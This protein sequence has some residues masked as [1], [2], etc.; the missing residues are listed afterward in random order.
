MGD[1][2]N[3]RRVDFPAYCRAFEAV[4]D[5]PGW[6]GASICG[7]LDDGAEEVTTLDAEKTRYFI[8]GAFG[9]G[10]IAGGH[11]LDQ[12]IVNGLRELYGICRD[13]WETCMDSPAAQA[14]RA[15]WKSIMDARQELGK[16]RGEVSRLKYEYERAAEEVEDQAALAS[17]VE[18]L[19]RAVDGELSSI[20]RCLMAE[21]S[22]REMKSIAESMAAEEK[23]IAAETAEEEK[24]REEIDRLN[25]FSVELW[26]DA[27]RYLA[28]SG[29]KRHIRR[30]MDAYRA[31]QFYPGY[32][33]SVESAQVRFD[34]AKKM[35]T[36]LIDHWSG[37]RYWRDD[38]CT[39]TLTSS[40][41]CTNNYRR[42][43]YLGIGSNTW[44]TNTC[45]NDRNQLGIG[46]GID[47]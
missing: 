34:M 23:R 27:E 18:H 40:A 14:V 6:S 15:G 31:Y 2:K 44:S 22:L 8:A 11:S 37:R 47:R 33:D 32:Q 46:S 1:V 10:E 5:A 19:S 35:M 16:K 24:M 4:E 28:K 41:G 9:A 17:R 13:S 3:N 7:T 43:C 39:T 20:E 45:N 30:A 36:E 38:H 21:R 12:T 42:S 26:A 29:T 25:G